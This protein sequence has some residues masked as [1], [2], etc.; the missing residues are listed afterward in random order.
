MKIETASTIGGLI[1]LLL[2]ILI[3]SLLVYF[4]LVLAIGWPVTWHGPLGA[5][6]CGC[7]FVWLVSK[8]GEK[9]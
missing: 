6:L 7:G 4:G 2:S 5:W 3:G 9:P 1:G 8:A